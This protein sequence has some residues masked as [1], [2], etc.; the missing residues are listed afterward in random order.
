M[1]EAVYILVFL[2]AACPVV[3]LGLVPIMVVGVAAFLATMLHEALDWRAYPFPFFASR[4]TA[5][6]TDAWGDDVLDR[7]GGAFAAMCAIAATVVPMMAVI[8]FALIWDIA[9]LPVQLVLRWRWLRRRRAMRVMAVL[10]GGL[11]KPVPIDYS[12]TTSLRVYLTRGVK[13]P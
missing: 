3:A 1:R 10:L 13:N 2:L 6:L 12:H 4:W 8:G 11:E 9:T 5:W 7:F